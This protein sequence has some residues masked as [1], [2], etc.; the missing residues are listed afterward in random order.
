MFWEYSTLWLSVGGIALLWWVWSR[1]EVAEPNQWLL[2][3]RNGKLVKAGVGIRLWR[4]WGDMVVSFTSTMQRVTF[5]TQVY[6]KENQPVVVRGFVLW[7]VNPEGND[8]FLAFS[9]LGIENKWGQRTRDLTFHHALNR[10]QYQAFRRMLEAALRK[11]VVRLSLPALLAD[12]KELGGLIEGELKVAVKGWGVAL[13]SLEVT[14]TDVVEGALFAD[15]QAA[16]VEGSKRDALRIRLEA[17]QKRSEMELE[18]ERDIALKRAQTQREQE[19]QIAQIA[20]EKEEEKARLFEQELVSRQRQLAQQ[21][22][23]DALQLE[24]QHT[25]SMKRLAFDYARRL[26]DERLRMVLQQEEQQRAFQEVEARVSREKALE[27][28]LLENLTQRNALEE[29]KLPEVRQAEITRWIV[30]EAS[31]ALRQLPLRDIRWY[32][33]DAQGGPTGLLGGLIESLQRLVEAQTA[34]KEATLVRTVEEAQA[35]ESSGGFG[36]MEDE[37][38]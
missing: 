11:S 30:Q 25:L 18:Q 13:E 10:A 1:Y 4:G 28:A 6:T 14:G 35:S 24:A 31:Q 19:V 2:L 23:L 36:L 20:L 5:E 9:K 27:S 17:Q 16:Y 8:P 12:P 38:P 37:G 32:S 33:S 26:E 29:Q 22:A 3:V 21:S 34:S 15:L 7:S